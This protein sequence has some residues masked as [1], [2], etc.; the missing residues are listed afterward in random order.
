MRDETLRA[1]LGGLL[2]DTSPGPVAFAR[3]LLGLAPERRA[4]R[5]LVS[6]F[7]HLNGEHPGLTLPAGV[8][9]PVLPD[10]GVCSPEESP[11]EA[12]EEA[13]A[14]H[15]REA[16]DIPGLLNLLEDHLS[17]LPSS[18]APDISRYDARKLTAAIA[19]CAAEYG[20]GEGAMFLLYAGDFSGIQKFIFT[21]STQGALASMRSRSFFLEFAM[22]HYIDELLWAC[23]MSRANLLYSGG[24]HCY[25]LLPNTPGV[26]RALESW[27]TR[28]NDWLLESFGTTL[29]L[30]QGYTPCTAGDLTNT[31]AAREPYA[32]MFRRVSAAVAA[33]KLHR[34]SP[35]QIRALNAETPE[36]PEREC[37][38]CGRS[39]GLDD[40]GR[41]PWCALFVDLSARMLRCPIYFVYEKDTNAANFV[42][43]GWNGDRWV[44]LMD[45]ATGK[46][47]LRDGSRPLRQYVKN[48]SLPAFPNAL[49]LY[50]GDYAAHRQVVDLA[51]NGRSARYLA[52]C[53]MDVDNL[54]HAFV[55]G[56]R[57]LGE[58][59]PEKR[60]KYL[61]L[62]RTAAFSRQ[63]S[64]FFKRH[65]NA[66]LSRRE[67]GHSLSLAIVYSGGDDVFLVGA[68]DD[69]IAGANRIQ[70]T[71][72]R[73]CGGSLTLSA[74]ITLHPYHFPIRQAAAQC[75]LLEDRAKAVPGKNSLALFDPEGENVY[76]W[77]EFRDRVL[78]EKLALLRQYLRR[79]DQDLSRVFLRHLEDLL[80]GAREDKLNLAR[81]A[82]LLARLE[83]QDP[84]RRE[85][86]RQF[87]AAVYRWALSPEDRRQLL[88]AIRFCFYDE[89]REGKS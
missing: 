36:D 54:G 4:D 43:P 2:L 25:L 57:Q 75:A 78:G 18:L 38:V 71:F 61:S 23:G 24:G 20:A 70:E 88:T 77:Q 27:N 22:E 66:I 63:M 14:R 85:A 29:F 58:T 86:Y 16:E 34:Y 64:L 3:D 39:G 32:A 50:V 56:F 83:P 87:S 12:L 13:L 7:T 81:C 44:R 30:A 41:C 10:A 35:R 47:L 5:C 8:P 37:V 9:G 49:R 31:P 28:F 55:S 45:E 67:E 84:R 17:F 1:T 53:R 80:A 59:D 15:G 60:D 72:H 48:E 33:H 89:R 65:I 76:S 11:E 6:V 42:L 74:G 26:I 73:F 82:Y 19:A 52:V 69:I 46:A 51:A 21:V 40:N 62:P 79:E 68:W